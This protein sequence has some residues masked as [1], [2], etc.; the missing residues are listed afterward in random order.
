MTLPPVYAITLESTPQRTQRLKK[1]LE[2]QNIQWTPWEGFDAAQWGLATLHP[3]ML[4]TPERIVEQK[5]VGLHLSHWSLWQHL[6]K[7]EGEAFTVLEDDAQFSEGWQA[8][9]EQAIQSLPAC[10]EML[11]I[12]SGNTFD[13]PKMQWR[14]NVWDVRYPQCTHAYIV[15]K[16]ALDKLLKTARKAW[17]PIDIA[18]AIASYPVMNVFTVLPRIVTQHGQEYIAE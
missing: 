7:I 13:K 16:Q 6:S 3:Y 11:L 8:Q 5:H 4:C 17:A 10:W 9:V 18:L 1:H 2:A 14:N 12:G 15:R